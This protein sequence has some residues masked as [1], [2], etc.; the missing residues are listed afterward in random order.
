MNGWWKKMNKAVLI[1]DNKEIKTIYSIKSVVANTK[2]GYFEITQKLY[3]HDIITIHRFSDVDRVELY[4]PDENY[5][6][7]EKVPYKV[8]ERE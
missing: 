5:H 7:Y 4:K 3:H 8:I 1:K 6:R 2:Y